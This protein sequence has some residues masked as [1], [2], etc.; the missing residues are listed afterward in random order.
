MRFEN[1]VALVTGAGGDIGR[2]IALRLAAE[3]ARVVVANFSQANADVTV[4]Q[5]RAAGGEAVAVLGDVSQPADA[6]RMVA[7][8]VEH[9]GGLDVLVNNAGISPMGSVT[10]TSFELWER[11][12]RIDLTGVF[13]GCK[14]AIPAIIARGGGSIVNVAG[15]LGLYAMPA[16]SAYCAAKAG[17]VNL[18]RQMAID[19]SP[20]GIRVNV[21]CPGYIETRL[22]SAIPD[23]VKSMFLAKLP[24][25][26]AGTPADIADAGAFLAS[27]EARYVT[28]AILTVDRG[29]STGLFG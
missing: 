16:K 28:G 5:I 26:F 29:Q 14:Y 13:L 8:A 21:I 2:G 6:E 1:K 25:P 10:D 19:Y 17:V 22:N 24:L 4:S 3:G 23:D 9:F 12:L 27:A 18:T 7:A 11:T 15:T 20:H